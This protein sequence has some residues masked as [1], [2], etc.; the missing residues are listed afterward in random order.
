MIYW[1]FYN[2]LN[3]DSSNLLHSMLLDV[4]S[5]LL[6]CGLHRHC[7]LQKTF[8]LSSSRLSVLVRS[9]CMLAQSVQQN[10]HTLNESLI[11]ALIGKSTGHITRNHAWAYFITLKPYWINPSSRN[12]TGMISSDHDP[13]A[14]CGRRSAFSTVNVCR[15]KAS[16]TN[17]DAL[18]EG[19]SSSPKKM[20][21]TLRIEI[22]GE[23]LGKL[24]QQCLS[25]PDQLLGWAWV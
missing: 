24:L 23:V 1:D 5:S 16:S 17:T 9:A 22:I 20:S 21:T 10:W 18:V 6:V 12:G 13:V 4:H 15:R 25:V 8:T 19:G 14:R 11:E 2:N 7:E 3:F